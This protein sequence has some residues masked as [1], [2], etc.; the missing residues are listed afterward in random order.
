MLEVGCGDNLR[1][2]EV[3]T[4][5]LPQ[6]LRQGAFSDSRKKILVQRLAQKKGLGESYARLGDF[7][8]ALRRLCYFTNTQVSSWV[9]LVVLV[10]PP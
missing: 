10:L 3:W 5:Q 6:R 2:Q 1:R 8:I 4:E 9:L 7:Y